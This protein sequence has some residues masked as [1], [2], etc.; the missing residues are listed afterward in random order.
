[1]KKFQPCGVVAAGKQGD[2]DFTGLS[3]APAPSGS[4]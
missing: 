4:S 3:Q 1:M 2:I